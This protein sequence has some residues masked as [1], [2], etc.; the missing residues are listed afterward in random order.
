MTRT[1]SNVFVSG[2]TL[3]L[4]VLVLHVYSRRV[5]IGV[6]LFFS[7]MYVPTY[8]GLETRSY[9]QS[10]FLTSLSSWLLLSLSFAARIESS[11]LKIFGVT[12]VSGILATANSGLAAHPLFQFVLSAH[13]VAVCPLLFFMGLKSRATRSL[14]SL[15]ATP[16]V[17]VPVIL[18]LVLWGF[19]LPYYYEHYVAGGAYDLEPGYELV[20]VHVPHAEFSPISVICPSCLASLQ[21]CWRRCFFAPV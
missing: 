17:V 13:A 3:C 9:A 19:A 20:R 6:A 11:Q 12:A 15:R 14:P 4:Y 18:F 10:M 2:A 16:I 1:L 21:R 8:Y 5:A 7:L